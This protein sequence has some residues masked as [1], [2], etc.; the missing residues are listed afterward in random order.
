MADKKTE[1]KETAI[2]K[3]NDNL[4]SAGQKVAEHKKVIFIGIGVIAVIAAFVISYLFIYRNPRL[5]H[6]YWHQK[7]KFLSLAW[8]IHARLRETV[9]SALRISTEGCRTPVERN[10]PH[11]TAL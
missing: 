8:S 6:A 10:R 7:I 3:L 9:I 1:E 2:E 4:S 5:Q 11:F